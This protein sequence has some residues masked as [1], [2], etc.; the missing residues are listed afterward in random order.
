MAHLFLVTDIQEIVLVRLEGSWSMT[1]RARQQ[2]AVVKSCFTT[3]KQGHSLSF[4]DLI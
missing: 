1:I 4:M 2:Y 3:Y